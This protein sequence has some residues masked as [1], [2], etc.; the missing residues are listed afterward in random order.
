MSR[1]RLLAA[2]AIAALAAGLLV[3]IPAATAESLVPASCP[4]GTYDTTAVGGDDFEPE[5]EAGWSIQ[6]AD[7]WTPG[8]DDS[9]RGYLHGAI[10]DAADAE[11]A[12]VM[13]P[14]S[15]PA[16]KTSVL[17]LQHSYE[18]V[19]EG[20]NAVTG[21]L[22]IA[23]AETF[24]PLDEF[25]GTAARTTTEYDLTPYAGQQVQLRFRIVGGAAEAPAGTGWY[26]HDA[27]FAACNPAVLPSAP[28]SVS[29]V[30]G[31]GKATVRW[32]PPAQPGS[33]G[34]QQYQITVS[35]GASVTT[36]GP[37]AR[38]KTIT[39][40]VNG[41]SYTFTVVAVNAVG[42]SPPA[43]TKLIGTKLDATAPTVVT[44][45]QS[46]TIKGKLVRV[47]T[48][49]GFGVRTVAL[50][51]RKPGT[52][53][54]SHVVSTQ[55]SSTGT[56]AFTR[57]PKR[58]TVY[59]VVFTSGSIKYLGTVSPTRTVKVRPKVTGA[60]AD[61]SVRSGQVAK[62]SG[63]V[64]PDHAGRKIILQR[65]DGDQVVQ[66]FVDYLNS[67]SRYAFTLVSNAPGTSY[68]RAYLPA[69]DDHAAGYSPKRKIV[70]S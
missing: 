46:A 21:Q 50:Q 64:A 30:G 2:A 56:Y 23:V 29:A 9:G 55:T 24:T 3:A 26:L 58:N 12:A 39:G 8:A 4:A 57:T 20:Q 43:A 19:G 45:G 10:P 32:Q 7:S 54:W 70:V 36:A 44:Y 16:G 38:S 5:P 62:F 48:A 42:V 53:S 60:F 65:L 22:E 47:D 31:I 49:S 14:V 18:F 35:P 28:Q 17:A 34:V 68:F 66:E 51:L 15:L 13:P 61:S 33:G 52:T 67:D 59:R 1:T 37:A 11:T 63:S 69:H 25:S 40:L 41:T 6:P 27:Q